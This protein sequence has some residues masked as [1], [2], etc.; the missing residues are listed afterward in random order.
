[1]SSLCGIIYTGS[2]WHKH[3][4]LEGISSHLLLK[5]L[6]CDQPTLFSWTMHCKFECNKSKACGCTM[7]PTTTRWFPAVRTGHLGSNVSCLRRQINVW[8]LPFYTSF[9][10]IP[11]ISRSFTFFFLCDYIVS[12]CV[13]LKATVV[14]SQRG[15]SSVCVQLLGPAPK[16]W[17][18]T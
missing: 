17:S 10:F 4:N 15:C 12:L 11:N 16:W 8:T 6:R 1:M 5:S 18:C 2:Y 7:A 14:A 3:Q 9:E 13:L